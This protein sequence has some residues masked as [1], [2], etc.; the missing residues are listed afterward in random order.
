MT[1]PLPAAK[2]VR[3]LLEVM[4]GRDIEVTTG[5][6][7]V[8]PA[9]QPGAVLGVYTDDSL[10]LSTM[11]VL[12][13]PLAAYAGAALALIPPGGA[14]AA[15]EDGFL[16]D[17]LLENIA[18]ILNIMTSLFNVDGAPHHRLY[19][20]Y[21]AGQPLPTDVAQWTLAYVPRLGRTV[22]VQG[23]GEGRVSVII[24][25]RRAAPW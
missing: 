17:T 13:L 20:T 2:D 23:D 12:D 14:E 21:S 19:A 8:D 6:E 16:P 1:T 15:V 4:L 3:D 25:P 11:I 5:A 18:E 9:Q 7:P 10:A 24:V 22:D